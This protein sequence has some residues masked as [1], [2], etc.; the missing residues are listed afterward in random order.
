MTDMLR[1]EEHR[2]AREYSQKQDQNK[3]DREIMAMICTEMFPST[4][5]YWKEERRDVMMRIRLFH[6]ERTIS[7]TQ[8]GPSNMQHTDWFNN[9]N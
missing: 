7:N 4:Q 8:D 5:Q 2:R 1:F 3:I 6:E 9:D